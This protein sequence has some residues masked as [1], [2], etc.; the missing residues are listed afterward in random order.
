[1]KKILFAIIISFPSV[2]LSQSLS[3]AELWKRIENTQTYQQEEW[4]VRKAQEE[5]NQDKINKLPLFYGD[6]NLQRNLIIPTTPV[7]A[8][9]FDPNAQAGAIVP[10]QFATKWSSKAGIQLEWNIFNPKNNLNNAQNKLILEKTKLQQQDVLEQLKI[11]ATLTY[12][13]IVLATLQYEKAKQDSATYAE[14]LDVTKNRYELG[15]VNSGEYLAAQQEMERRNIQLIEAWSVLEEASIELRNSLDI[16]DI[17]HIT[18]DI[19]GILATVENVTFVDN[20]MKLLGVEEQLTNLQ[21]QQIKKQKLPT[22]T[23]NSYLGTQFF[24]NKLDLYKG[25]N[26]FGNS[27]ANIAL[28]IPISDWVWQ[29]P[30]SKKAEYQ[31]KIDQLKSKEQ[32]L[33]ERTEQGQKEIKINATQHKIERLNKILELAVQHQTEQHKAYLEGR[34]L[35]TIYNKTVLDVNKAQQDIWQAQYELIKQIIEEL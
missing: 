12:T 32:L 8:I 18:T 35:V 11:D 22:L 28:R 9:A 2:A 4:K 15:R 7:P 14:I 31:L 33:I 10:L 1:M 20:K 24:N 21:I 30:Q 25:S 17:Q 16:E 26:W 27:Y 19:A 34:I 23:F 6:A 13:S 29:N 5:L 3:I